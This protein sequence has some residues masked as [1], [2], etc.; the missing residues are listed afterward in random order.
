MI[1]FLKTFCQSV[2]RIKII[3]Q[4]DCF[5]KYNLE[6]ELNDIIE[7]EKEIKMN[8]NMKKKLFNFK[9][10]TKN[11]YRK[12]KNEDESMIGLNTLNKS[13]NPNITTTETFKYLEIFQ[14]LS[15]SEYGLGK[16]IDDFIEEFKKIISKK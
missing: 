11:K 12:I 2:E 16:K 14:I 10:K 3:R 9:N 7:K 4:S 1:Q 8:M 6:K 13:L 5:Y 15:K